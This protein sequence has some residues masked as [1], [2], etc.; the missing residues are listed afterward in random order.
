M[1]A[2]AA[3]KPCGERNGKTCLSAEEVAEWR[4][5]P[6][7]DGD[8]AGA[9]AAAREALWDALSRH[10]HGGPEQTGG[11]HW[12]VGCVSL[13]ITQRCNLDCTLCYLSDMS[14]AVK[15]IPL[16]EVFRRIDDIARR[17]GP[18]TNV[19]VSGGDP[20]LRKREELVAIVARLA[21][22]GMSAS[23]LTNGIKASRDLLRDLA[24]AGLKDVAFHVDLT[25]ERKGF[26]SEA[27]LNAVR[28]DY[29]ARAGGLG[30]RILFNTTV[31]DDNVAEMAGLVR[32]FV[33]RADDLHM[34]SFQL[35]AETGRGVMG[36]RKGGVSAERMTEDIAAGTGVA[37]DFALP[38]IGHPECN[39]YSAVLVSG[40]RAFPF[41]EPKAYWRKLFQAAARHAGCWRTRRKWRGLAAMIAARPDLAALGLGHGLKALW[42]MRRELMKTG[43][44]TKLSFLV[45]NF[46][47]AKSLDRTRC[48]SCIFMVATRDGPMSMC[49]HNARRDGELL[50][51]VR[52]EKGWW[53]PL[54]GTI[55]PHAVRADAAPEAL[56]LKRLKGRRRA[57]ALTRRRADREAARTP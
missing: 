19:Q 24:G 48:E 21:E 14:E 42:T 47:D 23:L 53:D 16:A 28:D 6:C 49:V 31:Y 5:A 2:K 56:P 26:A 22:K 33:S 18:G 52:T 41:F 13:E 10:G 9:Q 46:M 15:D 20:T 3:A 8:S 34:V 17:Y 50:K 44:A 39:R 11:R 27:A 12:P 30:L 37:L 32:Y 54:T 57:A 25:Q 40:G 43:K 29:I 7:A 4:P 1:E 55:R 38:L 51:P 36:A 35:Q 45:H